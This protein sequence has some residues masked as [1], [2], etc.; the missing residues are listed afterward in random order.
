[1]EKLVKFIFEDGLEKIFSLDASIKGLRDSNGKRPVKAVFN[2]SKE[3]ILDNVEKRNV[4]CTVIPALNPLKGE[5]V[6]KDK[7]AVINE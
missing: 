5:V 7:E 4:Y 3:C 2:F 6:Y 1:M